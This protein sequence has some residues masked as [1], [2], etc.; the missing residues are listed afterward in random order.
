MIC[1]YWR[2]DRNT[3]LLAL[4]ITRCKILSSFQSQITLMDMPVFKAIQPEVGFL[5]SSLE[6]SAWGNVMI[7]R[8]LFLF[9]NAH[10]LAL[11]WVLWICNPAWV[12][13][14]CHLL[15]KGITVLF[16][17][18]SCLAL[19]GV[20]LQDKFVKCKN[21]L[22]SLLLLF[23]NSYLIS[24]FWLLPLAIIS[25]LDCI[26]CFISFLILRFRIINAG[27]KLALFNLKS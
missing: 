22:F 14:V 16:W 10:F 1:S 5:E 6:I 9:K 26:N 18:S 17:K 20:F 4:H 19:S 11:L 21:S 8:M 3:S 25:I 23:F 27:I 24:D 13:K 2:A 15:P 12:T 7:Q